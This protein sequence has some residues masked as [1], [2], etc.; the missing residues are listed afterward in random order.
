MAGVSGVVLLSLVVLVSAG[1]D[2]EFADGTAD[3]D[4][5]A[6]GTATAATTSPTSGGTTGLTTDS[7][8]GSSGFTT[9]GTGSD[10]TGYETDQGPAATACEEFLCGPSAQCEE[11]D[12][13]PFCTC[14]AGYVPNGL[15]CLPCVAVEPGMIPAEVPTTRATFEFTLDGQ[16]SSTSGLEFA[17]I[18]LHNQSSGDIVRVGQTNDSPPTSL[19]M[20]PGTYD[21]RYEFREGALLPRNSDAIIG[22]VHV[23]AGEA[24]IPINVQSA[25]VRGQITLGGGQADTPGLNFGRLF[26]V[27]PKTDDRISLGTTQDDIYE[28]RVTPGRYEVHYEFR[29]SQGEAP[30]NGDALVFPLVLEPGSNE[31]DIDIPVAELSGDILVDGDPNPSGLDTG[32][33]E[34]R[35]PIT[36]DRFALGRTQ[37]LSYAKTLLPGSYE[38]IYTAREL[39]PR[40]PVNQGTVAGMLEVQPGAARQNIDLRTAVISGEFTVQGEAP[41]ENDSDDGIVVLRDAGGGRVFLGNTQTGSYSRRVLVGEYDIIYAQETASLTMPVNTQARIGSIAVPRQKAFDIEIPVVEL[42]GNMTIDGEAA[43]DSPYDDGRLFLRNP[44]TGD[45]V[46]LGNTREGTYAAR[47]IP[48]TYNVVYSNE[49]SDT[50]LPVNQG[51]ILFEDLAVDRGATIDIDVSVATLMGSVGIQGAQVSPNEGTG[52]LFLRDVATDDVV[53]L[54]DTNA[55]EFTKPLA[56]G[57]Y[58]MEYRGIPANGGSLGTTLPANGNAAFACYEIL[59]D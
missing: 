32:D 23:P 22:Q 56:S 30:V 55:M 26:L 33:L 49:F 35:D 17:R 11:G 20:V 13:G 9:D 8:F 34:L 31:W 2:R 14:S 59:T 12:D 37:D 1:C 58:I 46:L 7:T 15:D 48:G 4:T 47:V 41:P 50:V 5:D 21:V 45:S 54:G 57:T 42:V 28:L 27:D 6:D 43:P 51:A 53:F 44:V 24:T 3:T 29:E 19:L 52:Q 25:T 16:P 18:T 38:L 40:N 39:G 10:G 36:G